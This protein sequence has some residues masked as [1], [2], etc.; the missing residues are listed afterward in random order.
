MSP[1]VRSRRAR[2][3]GVFPDY[4]ISQD[5]ARN[6][7]EVLLAQI[8]ELNADIAPD[9][10]PW[11]RAWRDQA[12]GGGAV[13]VLEDRPHRHQRYR[14]LDPPPGLGGWWMTG[15]TTLVNGGYTMK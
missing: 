13:S 4:G 10:W 6:V 14:P 15:Q 8:G 11:R 7:F 1:A 3:G 2:L 5:W 9:V 12:A